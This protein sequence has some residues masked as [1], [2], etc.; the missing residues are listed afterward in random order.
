MDLAYY[1]YRT[2]GK[3]S[4]DKTAEVVHNGQGKATPGF[5]TAWRDEKHGGGFIPGNNYDYKAPNNR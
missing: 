2:E 4:S 1:D 5:Y 3:Y